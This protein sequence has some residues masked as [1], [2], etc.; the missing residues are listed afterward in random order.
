VS[1]PPREGVQSTI[2]TLNSAGIQVTMCTGDHTSTATAI[3]REVG[4]IKPNT[5][6][7]TLEEAL[8]VRIPTRV[9]GANPDM[10]I[11]PK[12][13]TKGALIVTGAQV[14]T[15]DQYMWNWYC[16]PRLFDEL[17]IYGNIVCVWTHQ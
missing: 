16:S 1:D 17:L 13:F 7:M 5:V 4:I 6:V 2:T 10:S 15:F 3:S 11:R 14:A 8:Q 12:R 9:E